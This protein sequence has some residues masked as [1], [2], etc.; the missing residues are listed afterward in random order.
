MCSPMRRVASVARIH[1][2]MHEPWVWLS[3]SRTGLLCRFS[4]HPGCSFCVLWSRQVL[5]AYCRTPV[6]SVLLPHV[7]FVVLCVYN[8]HYI[9]E[10]CSSLLPSVGR[11]CLTDRTR[12]P[13]ASGR[14]DEGRQLRVVRVRV[15]ASTGSAASSGPVALP[16]HAAAGAAH[17]DASSRGATLPERKVRNRH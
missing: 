13:P 2:R 14:C 16:Q 12:P 17:A 5:E 4:I 3:G 11:S 10:T 8:M 15:A 9:I 6:I 7:L 1:R